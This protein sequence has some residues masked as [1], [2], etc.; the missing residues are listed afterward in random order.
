MS[1]KVIIY[2][3]RKQS[4]QVYDVSTPE[5]EKEG[6]MLL[7]E[8]MDEWDVFSFD[9]VIE[10][11]EEKIEDLE[12]PELEWDDGS[13]AIDIG[14]GYIRKLSPEQR[15]EELEEAKEDLRKA[16]TNQRLYEK[17]K[18]ADFDAAKKIVQTVKG[19]PYAD[20]RIA[21]VKNHD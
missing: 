7:F 8:D 20:Y 16:R 1:S 4:P 9:H 2:Q 19:R 13:I 5:K 15:E 14:D 3:H 17:V 11:R 21:T 12:N 10:K 18:D 6:Y